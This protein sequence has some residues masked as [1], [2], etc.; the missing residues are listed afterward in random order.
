MHK[1]LKIVGSIV[2]FF[3]FPLLSV[4]AA[5]IGKVISCTGECYAVS[6]GNKRALSRGSELTQ[7]EKLVTGKDGN[8]QVRFTDTGLVAVRPNSEYTVKTYQHK[9]GEKSGKFAADLAKGQLRALTGTIGKDNSKD[10]SLST[11]S[12]TIG[13][14][15]TSYSAATSTGECADKEAGTE[16]NK[17]STTENK[18][19]ST[20]ANSET[21]CEDEGG[22]QV[23]GWHGA[24][25]ADTGNAANAVGPDEYFGFV[26][27]AGGLTIPLREFPDSFS[28][29]PVG[30][31]PS[32]EM[33]TETSTSLQDDKAK[34]TLA[35]EL[36]EEF[37]SEEDLIADAELEEE[38]DEDDEDEDDDEDDPPASGNNE[39]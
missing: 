21:N 31:T 12:T 16:E 8:L 29:T 36:G 13:V 3:S 20:A 35:D 17:S 27:N 14:E 28:E 23:V 15:G 19:P 9:D 2:F 7:G 30:E 6:G 33:S 37:E 24:A 1:L 32:N 18:S 26:A 4:E 34:Q 10:Y 25:I 5:S 38:D 39:E 22:D 11:K